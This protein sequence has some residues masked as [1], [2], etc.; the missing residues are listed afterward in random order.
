M[1]KTKQANTQATSVD[2]QVLAQAVAMALASMQ[3]QQRNAEATTAATDAGNRAI[4]A[5]P[6]AADNPPAEISYNKSKQTVTVTLRVGHQGYESSSGKT[7]ILG[8]G[9]FVRIGDYR[10]P[11]TGHSEPLKLSYTLLYGGKK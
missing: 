5:E 1:S 2:P 4:A 8:N 3:Q 6:T 9:N 7:R 10:N 11:V